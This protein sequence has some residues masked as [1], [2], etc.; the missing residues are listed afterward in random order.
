MIHTS[1]THVSVRQPPIAGAIGGN[2]GGLLYLHIIG[3][4][5]T[6][7]KFLKT[8]RFTDNEI[9]FILAHESAHIFRNHSISTLIYLIIEKLALGLNNQNYNQIELAKAVWAALAPSKLPLN[10]EVSR[11][12]EYEADELAARLT[13]DFN[14]CVSCLKKLCG[15]NLNAPS[16][17][18]ELGGFKL[19]MMTVRQRIKELNKRLS[20]PSPI[21]S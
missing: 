6:D 9:L 17:T 12:N 21:S 10:V 7:F 15:G 14:T 20:Q 3:T 13:G 5:Y 18:W 11:N 1:I 2:A 19:P 8:N 4:I 16:H